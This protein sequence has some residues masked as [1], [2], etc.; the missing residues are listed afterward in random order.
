MDG[1]KKRENFFR[2]V[3]DFQSIIDFQYHGDKSEN[4]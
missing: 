2:S 4:H 3:N 1:D